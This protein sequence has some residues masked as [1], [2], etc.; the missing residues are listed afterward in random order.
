MDIDR[1]LR[2]LRL[3]AF[4]VFAFFFA[5]PAQA[6][7]GPLPGSPVADKCMSDPAAPTMPA[8][9]TGTDAWA[10]LY[11]HPNHPALCAGPEEGNCKHKGYVM[12]GDSVLIGD[13]CGE[14]RFMAYRGAKTRT[15][16]WVEK[17]LYASDHPSMPSDNPLSSVERKSFD[18]ACR[19]AAKLLNERRQSLQE[20]DSTPVLPSALSNSKSMDDLPRGLGTA[21]ANL[22]LWDIVVSD[23]RILGRPF[24]A[25][26]YSSAGPTHH[27]ELWDHGF[28]VQFEI[29]KSFFP[30]AE[31]E[32]LEDYCFDSRYDNGYRAEDLVQLL[33]HP[34]YMRVPI[35]NNCIKLYGFPRSLKPYPACVLEEYANGYVALT[36]P[37]NDE[38]QHGAP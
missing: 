27:F 2:S 20:P 5:H 4:S 34:Y 15:I 22:Y 12:R 29:P 38:M 21:G 37:E 26:S 13:A 1:L 36:T 6:D 18:A 9:V 32:Q 14:W 10:R 28:T 24:K 3:P 31:T 11:I 7:G 8:I 16:G 35:S 17:S 19:E 25:L 23:A 30:V 33:G